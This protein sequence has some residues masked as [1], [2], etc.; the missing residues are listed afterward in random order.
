MKTVIKFS[1]I[2][3]LAMLLF[4]CGDENKNETDET[5]YFGMETKFLTQTFGHEADAK[6]VTVKTNQTFTATSSEPWCTTEI[7]EGEKVEQLKIKVED[8]DVVTQRT[9][10]VT[11]AC[12]GYE[13]ITVAITQRGVPATLSVAPLLPD[14]VSGEG[15]DITF[16]VTANADWDYSIAEDGEW[17][18]EKAKT[19]TTLTLAA[20]Y[21]SEPVYKNTAL[22]FFLPDFPDREIEITVSQEPAFEPR[23]NV[24]L[25]SILPVAKTGGEVTFAIDANTNYT[26]VLDDDSWLT[27][28]TQSPSSLTLEAANNASS[29]GRKTT[30]TVHLTNYPDFSCS[31]S[32]RQSGF[33]DMLDV[34]FNA[35]G[36]AEDVSA[37]DNTVEWKHSDNNPLSVAYSSVYGRNIVTFNPASNGGSSGS[38]YR[39]DYASNTDFQNKLA[40]GHSFECLV[41]FDVDYSSSQNYETK[42]FSTH[43]GGGTGFLIANQSQATGPNGI[44]FLPNVS[45]TSG[46]VWRWANSRIKPDGTSFYHLVG[47][48]SK[49]DAKAYIYVNG[50]LKSTVDALGNYRN[51]SSTTCYWVALG[52]DAGNNAIQGTF[53]GSMVIARIYDSPLTASEAATLY[54]E[55]KP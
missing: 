7:L 40:D 32:I 16:T 23:L 14:T 50:E 43:E 37:M 28:K 8:I 36:T 53:K 52:G 24:T 34:L 45:T 42:F 25:S 20:I 17:L 5:P 31:Y 1:M 35:D 6:Y 12:Q 10:T 11:V 27:K 47:V 44:T 3:C 39:V 54:N 48:Y 22:K 30:L 51:P 55:I 49:E 13:S 29:G 15:G 9:A 38:Y 46:S 26:Y 18:S 19:E 33:A 21:N 41:K 4:A 2:A